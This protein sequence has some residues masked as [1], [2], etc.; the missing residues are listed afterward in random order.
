LSI[1]KK[2]ERPL[3]FINGHS[4]GFILEIASRGIEY[5]ILLDIE[6][7]VEDELSVFHQQV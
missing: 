5:W 4:L 7:L 3:N 2:K 6:I 1:K